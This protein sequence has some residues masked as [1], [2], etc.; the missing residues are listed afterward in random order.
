MR[1]GPRGDVRFLMEIKNL[2]PFINIAVIAL[3][4]DA[5]VYFVH[6][7]QSENS[8]SHIFIISYILCMYIVTDAYIIIRN[9]PPNKY[10]RLTAGRQ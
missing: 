6:K 7:L 2:F 3:Y 9:D 4:R 8:V 10:K 5:E 1:T